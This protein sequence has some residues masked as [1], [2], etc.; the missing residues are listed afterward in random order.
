MALR[1]LPQ[2][3]SVGL[4]PGPLRV[5]QLRAPGLRSPNWWPDSMR[6]RQALAPKL[7]PQRWLPKW[8][9][10]PQQPVSVLASQRWRPECLRGPQRQAAQL[11]SQHWLQGSLWRP[12]AWAPLTGPQREQFGW[13]Q[14]PDQQGRRLP[15]RVRRGWWLAP[16]RLAWVQRVWREGCRQGPLSG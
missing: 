6:V 8:L 7:W 4:L 11:W 13:R 3:S 14:A 2:Q 1:E 15:P 12:E 5:Q 9:Q 10:T 16:E